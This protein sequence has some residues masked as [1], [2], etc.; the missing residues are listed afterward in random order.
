[1]V[2]CKL[3]Y[4]HKDALATIAEKYP[5]LALRLK[6]CS[7]T[8]EKV[9]K[10][11][12]KVRHLRCYRTCLF[13]WWFSCCVLAFLR[14][15]YIR[16]LM[17]MR[18][19]YVSSSRRWQPQTPIAAR[20]RQQQTK[21][22]RKCLGFQ[23]VQPQIHHRQKLQNIREMMKERG[24]PARSSSTPLGWAMV[25]AAMAAVMAASA[26]ALLLLMRVLC[27]ARWAVY[28]MLC[29]QSMRDFRLK[30]PKS[31]RVRT[32]LGKTWPSSKQWWRSCWNRRSDR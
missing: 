24:Q 11:G 23:A 8:S 14:M 9:N 25:A 27:P 22:S 19:L 26:S 16:M 20:R 7:R 21:P 13:F 2:D 17:A 32:G 10:K 3:C 5:E 31:R 18:T 12:K 4:I 28:M 6:R 15:L 29:W 1:M 30:W